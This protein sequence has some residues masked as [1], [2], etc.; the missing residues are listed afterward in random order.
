MVIDNFK[1]GE[2]L[3]LAFG[4]IVVLMSVQIIISI[5]SLGRMNTGIDAVTQSSRNIGLANDVRNEIQKVNAALMT[6][7][8]VNDQ[9]TRTEQEKVFEEATALAKKALDKLGKT[10]QT[11]E[12]GSLLATLRG[13]VETSAKENAKVI[14]LM[15]S[16][17]TDLAMSNF[18]GNRPVMNQ[19][20]DLCNKVVHYQ[21]NQNT[22]YEQQAQTSYGKGRVI[23]GLIGLMTLVIAIG[24]A[25]FLT[26]S[27]VKPL[28][29]GVEA[30]NRL[31]AGDLTVKVEV[32]GRNE[33]SSLMGALGDTIEMLRLI[34]SEIKGA[35][36]SLASASSDLT[37][38]SVQ[39]SK[40]AEEQER[41]A[42]QLATASEKL[43]RT[44]TDVAKNTGEIASSANHA[45]DVARHG[46]HMVKETVSE[47]RAI[48][49]TAGEASGIVKLLGERSRQIGEIVEVIGNIAD[50]TNLLALNAA[51]EAARAGEHGR[52]FAVVADEVRKL[53]E[54]TANATK[55]I[56]ATIES[57]REE[58]E[59]A[60]VAMEETGKRVELG[61]NRSGES[62]KALQAI[63][64]AVAG[65]QDRTR[66]IASA[67]EE[68]NVTT[69]KI[70]EDIEYVA[71]V[72]GENSAAARQTTRASTE[73]SQLSGNLKEIL[74]GFRL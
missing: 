60:V 7:V 55:K 54:E 36:D 39:M 12:M 62:G 72:T 41:R 73:L 74:S 28:Q 46:E 3:Y 65:L 71:R 30:S 52:G 22:H 44:V 51:I 59:R 32:S 13:A 8:L 48:A 49:E 25:V 57:I 56:E 45:T 21:E 53:A 68:M 29:K 61:V 5:Y 35:A 24:T 23:L 67:T 19:I 4:I 10:G 37:A 40:G 69:S 70:A 9:A 2:R 64:Q 43:A 17:L 14:D 20:S 66:D 1:I 63:V 38:G 26:R 31:T 27:I 6:I 16:D 58:V 50:Q 15:E 34:M 42:S 18:I 47:I 33:L 11:K